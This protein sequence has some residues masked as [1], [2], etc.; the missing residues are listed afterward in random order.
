MGQHR[1]NSDMLLNV[2]SS[3]CILMQFF[4][5][6]NSFVQRLLREL[7]ADVNGTAKQSLPSSSFCNGASGKEHDTESSDRCIYPDLQQYLARSRV[8]AKRSRK[9]KI[10]NEKSI[11]GVHL[12]KSRSEDLTC[13]GED[14][15]V[16]QGNQ[17]D[18]TDMNFKTFS[19]TKEKNGIRNH[20]GD[21][22]VSENLQTVAVE[23]KNSFSSHVI[24]PNKK[25]SKENSVSTCYITFDY[26]NRH[27]GVLLIF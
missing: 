15:H 16:R 7:V 27:F 25:L 11:I 5:F 19:K 4:G 20:P 1:L 8:T 22:S 2:V 17:R 26:F 13:N 18:D 23:E 6:R 21:S 14:L 3:L 12:K 10:M 24:F 9:H